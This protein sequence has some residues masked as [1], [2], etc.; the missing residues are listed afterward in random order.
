[1]IWKAIV[2]LVLLEITSGDELLVNESKWAALVGRWSFIVFSNH[3]TD[4]KK[5]SPASLQPPIP[6]RGS[7]CC[8]A[9]LGLIPTR[10][11]I[12]AYCGHK[13]RGR[14]TRLYSL[15]QKVEE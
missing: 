12:G 10:E 3:R 6:I 8:D 4:K 7:P 15:Q 11:W 14:R 2:D 9:Y 13:L 5:K 1:M